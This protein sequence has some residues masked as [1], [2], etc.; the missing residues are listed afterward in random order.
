MNLPISMI[1]L[2]LAVAAPVV[3]AEPNM[4]SAAEKS[5]GWKL[6]FDG[7]SLNGWRGYK[8]ETIGEGWKVQDGAL[9]LTAAKAGDLITAGEFTDS[10]GIF[11]QRP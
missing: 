1:A 6:L 3:S 5:A 2:A 10:V 8:T 4:L 9:V 7:K 11:F